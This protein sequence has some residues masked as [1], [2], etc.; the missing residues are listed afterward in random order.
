LRTKSLIVLA[1]IVTTVAT[2]ITGTVLLLRIVTALEYRVVTLES[3]VIAGQQQHL[4]AEK[5]TADRLAALEQSVYGSL[6]PAARRSAP[7]T[8]AELWQRTR[9]A[10]LRRR[11]K[12]IEE[13]R[14][15]IETRR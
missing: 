5:M 8:P 4:A 12:A 10:E 7:K 3:Q 14:M 1:V 15:Q 9:D 6:E 13:W 2:G 11:L